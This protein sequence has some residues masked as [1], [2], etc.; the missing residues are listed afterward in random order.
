ML[1]AAWS[2]PAGVYAVEAATPKLVSPTVHAEV[3]RIINSGVANRSWSWRLP[4]RCLAK[5]VQRDSAGLSRCRSADAAAVSLR[6]P[7]PVNRLRA[8]KPLRS[9]GYLPTS[10]TFDSRVAP[11][12]SIAVPIEQNRNTPSSFVSPQMT[13]SCYHDCSD[14]AASYFDKRHHTEKWARQQKSSKK[15]PQD[16]RRTRE[17][18]EER[19]TCCCQPRGNEHALR[20]IG[21][22]SSLC[23]QRSSAVE[24]QLRTE[25]KHRDGIGLRRSRFA[26]KVGR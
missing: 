18:G 7:Y 4:I 11:H 20:S 15:G 9:G 22:R 5:G 13:A 3:S 19:Y 2:I 21:Q 26:A 1:T 6:G 10:S 16:R 14:L 17:R 23:S 12:S 25:G 8:G 24:A